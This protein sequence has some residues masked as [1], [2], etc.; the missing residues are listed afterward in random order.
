MFGIGG[1]EV[2]V[3]VVTALLI[4]G[5]PAVLGFWL[6]YQAGKKTGAEKNL[7]EQTVAQAPT[8]EEPHDE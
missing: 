2:L 4:F 7:D 5:A 3:I 6:G 1:T 8:D